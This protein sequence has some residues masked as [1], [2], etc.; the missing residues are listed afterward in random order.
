METLWQDIRY[1]LRMLIKKPGFTAVALVTLALGI[2][3][4]T[5]VFSVMYA[6]LLRSLPVPDPG[7]L[8]FV[9][10]RTPAG[11]QRGLSYAACQALREQGRSFTALGVVSVPGPFLVCLPGGDLENVRREYAGAGYFAALGVRP[12]AGRFFTYEEDHAPSSR[13]IIS[14]RFWERHFNRSRTAIGAIVRA[15]WADAQYTIIGVMAPGYSGITPEYATDI[16]LQESQ[17]RVGVRAGSEDPY[18]GWYRPLVRLKPGVSEKQLAA[19]LDGIY[20][21][22]VQQCAAGAPESDRPKLLGRRIILTAGAVGSPQLGR[23]LQKPLAVLM[24]MVALVLLLA[25]ANLGNMLLARTAARSREIAIRVAVGAGRGHVVRQLL[26]ESLLLAL[27]G[28][29]LGLMF[30]CWGAKVFAGFVAGYV[31][32]IDVSPDLRVFAFTALVSLGAGLLFGL[33]PAL[34]AAARDV[35]PV[36]K[37]AGT[38][39]RSGRWHPGKVL[40]V[41]QVALSI[42]LVAG[43]GL[44]LRTVANLTVLDTGFTREHVVYGEV[45]TTTGYTPQAD[46]AIRRLLDKVQQMPGILSVS[47][48]AVAVS[49]PSYTIEV[50]GYQAGPEEKPAAFLR[51]VS[52]GF[53]ETLRTP[54]LQGRSLERRDCVK[55]NA[56][57]VVVNESFVRRF[58]GGHSPLGRHV[59]AQFAGPKMGPFEI[60]GVAADARYTSPKTEPQ[61]EIYTPVTQFFGARL[62]L[63]TSLDAR[64]LLA[65]LPQ[66][67]RQAEPQLRVLEMDTVAHA[68]D[69]TLGQE[70]MLASLSGFF[71]LLALV[72]ASIGIFGVI[73]Y[74][75]AQRTREIGIR[76]AMGAS[77]LSVL[78]MVLRE[79]L[80]LLLA[81]LALGI[82]V[83]FAVGR[84]V[85]S[86]LYGLTP[87]DPATLTLAVLVLSTVALLASYLPARRAARI[88]PMVALRCE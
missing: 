25:C 87:S 30:A 85:A 31:A 69:K 61:P 4:N 14:H 12:A 67:V 72:L 53:F 80:V 29:A 21:Q 23:R 28:G 46:A 6:L 83:I 10:Q 27:A 42:V 24:V 40:V 45:V 57:V 64:T 15:G 3:A 32:R 1:G 48:G 26:T 74:A 35:A 52:D 49:T 34:Y 79:A 51:E 5:A 20:T 38:A 36:L 9:A 54:L 41:S 81:G 22:Y 84:F 86:L 60:V 39:P 88:D 66:F 58:C 19:E 77:R 78:W 59:T 70:R 16:W 13:V 76:M 56:Q 37:G 63:R 75:V 2:G 11:G 82:P 17:G 68:T 55:G 44:F 50:E 8:R 43:A 73:S 62:L 33:V 71:G 65:T 7:A 47:T 18:E